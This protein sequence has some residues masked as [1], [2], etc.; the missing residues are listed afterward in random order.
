VFL[1]EFSALTY[2]MSIMMMP[3]G[4]FTHTP[5]LLGVVLSLA[6]EFK[7]ILD[8]NPNTP[9]LSSSLVKGWVTKGS[10]VET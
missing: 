10:S 1:E 5:L 3:K 2:L 9:I 4:F 8:K 7:K 6:F